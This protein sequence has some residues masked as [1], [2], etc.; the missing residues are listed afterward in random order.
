MTLPSNQ[1]ETRNFQTQ[2]QTQSHL[3]YLKENKAPNQRVQHNSSQNTN[4]KEAQSRN[5]SNS[6]SSLERS[7]SQIFQSLQRERG[8]D[9]GASLIKPNQQH[10][11]QIGAS[12]SHGKWDVERREVTKGGSFSKKIKKSDGNLS[13]FLLKN[14]AS[15]TNSI[16]SESQPGESLQNNTILEMNQILNQVRTTEYHPPGG[17]R[18][19]SILTKM[20][21]ATKEHSLSVV[22]DVF[23]EDF[24]MI[25]DAKTSSSQARAPLSLV[26][27]AN[28][29]LIDKERR[30]QLGLESRLSNA[31]EI[32]PARHESRNAGVSREMQSFSEQMLMSFL[33]ESMNHKKAN[34]KAKRTPLDMSEN[35]E[36]INRIL[37]GQFSEPFPS[38]ALDEEPSHNAKQANGNNKKSLE[39]PKISDFKMKVTSQELKRQ[40]NT[41]K[42]MRES[43][44]KPENISMYRRTLISLQ[45]QLERSDER[46]LVYKSTMKG[47]EEIEQGAGRKG[48]GAQVIST[49]T[50]GTHVSKPG[51]QKPSFK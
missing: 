44:F 28:Q 6:N 12:Q 31:A 8:E 10:L 36:T 51:T 38:L 1:P 22:K 9:T 35:S 32:I 14:L 49:Q 11:M 39:K 27:S 3:L 45:E 29:Q 18:K 13:N 21:R 47:K 25:L 43:S 23:Q 41:L 48:N 50:R 40:L 5:N 34:R 20:S 37:K 30:R 19:G 26:T 24:S 46:N 7:I 4:Y 15:V 42:D 16:Y 17:L 33:K 2:T